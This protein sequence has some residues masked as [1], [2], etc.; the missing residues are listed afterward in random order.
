M[1]AHI[2]KAQEK[3]RGK[4]GHYPPLPAMQMFA[5]SFK[6]IH[7]SILRDGKPL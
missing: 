7:A 1:H 4:L 2:L 6:E 5:C 3:E